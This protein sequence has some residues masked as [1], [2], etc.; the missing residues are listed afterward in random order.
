MTSVSSRTMVWR[1]WDLS[2]SDRDVVLAEGGDPVELAAR[3]S[4]ALEVAEEAVVLGGPLIVPL[5]A[6]RRFAVL[7]ARPGSLSLRPGRRELTGA[8]LAARL[9][10]A[11]EVFVFV[12]TIGPSLEEFSASLFQEDPALAVALDALGSAAVSLL[13]SAALSRAQAKVSCKG[14]LLSPP[15]SPGQPGWPTEVGQ[16]EVFGA[17]NASLVGVSLTGGH[18]MLPRKSASFVVG[19]GPDASKPGWDWC[20]HCNLSSTCRYRPRG[21]R[22]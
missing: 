13:V 22:P 11:C 7:S 3:C 10:P 2:L 4:P 15:A 18:M 8:A 21:G 20:R 17:V 5:V 6:W 16:S 14:W 19:V 1:K 12:C 9:L